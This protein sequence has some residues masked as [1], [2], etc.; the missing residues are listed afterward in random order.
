MSHESMSVI[1]VS[2]LSEDI[3]KTR[4]PKTYGKQKGNPR[5]MDFLETNTR[6]DMK[7]VRVHEQLGYWLEN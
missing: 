5:E 7:R 4:Y 3:L 6:R 2:L 1:N